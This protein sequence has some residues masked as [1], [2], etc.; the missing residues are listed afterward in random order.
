MVKK[1]GSH[2][3]TVLYPNPWFNEVC[4]KRTTLLYVYGHLRTIYIAWESEIS[5]KA[6]VCNFIY[7][8]AIGQNCSKIVI[9]STIWETHMFLV[10]GPWYDPFDFFLWPF[11]SFCSRHGCAMWKF[12]WMLPQSV[13]TH[14]QWAPQQ[15][16]IIDDTSLWG[17]CF[18]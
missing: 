17:L 2:Y 5:E 12:S 6:F 7:S 11:S 14:F 3:M 15:K 9:G 18:K 8:Y 16:K 10:Q 13:S 4:Y 1:F